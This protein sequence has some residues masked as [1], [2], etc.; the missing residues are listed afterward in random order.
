[1]NKHAPIKNKYFGAN[2]ANFVTE[3]LRR[4]LMARFRLLDFALKWFKKL[5]KN[6]LKTFNHQKLLK[7]R[8]FGKLKAPFLTTKQKPI[9]KLI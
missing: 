6:I 1:M 8:R 4:A 9:I 3:V 5:K 7:T 2:D